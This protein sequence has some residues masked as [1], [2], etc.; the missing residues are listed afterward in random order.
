VGYSLLRF[1]EFG[2]LIFKFLDDL[3]VVFGLCFVVPPAF[4]GAYGG[5]IILAKSPE[6][7]IGGMQPSYRQ[8]LRR[9][10]AYDR[11]RIRHFSCHWW[12]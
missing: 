3:T 7:G 5:R 11:N 1:E 6:I 10:P 4:E 9:K 12:L 8:F 2:Y